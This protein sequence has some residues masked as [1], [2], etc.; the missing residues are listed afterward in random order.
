VANS[1]ENPSDLDFTDTLWQAD[2]KLRGTVDAAEYKHVVPGLL[3]LKYISDSFESRRIKLK[4]ELEKD[5]AA[6]RRPRAR[7]DART[8]RGPRLRPLLRLGRHVRLVH[9][10]V[11]CAKRPTTQRQM[12]PTRIEN[13]SRNIGTYGH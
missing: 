6:M 2:N 11:R 4:E 10:R 1:P 8:V 13:G 7:R 9:G 12:T 5:G 3:F